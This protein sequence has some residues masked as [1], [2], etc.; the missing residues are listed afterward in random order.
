MQ[1]GAA[2]SCWRQTTTGETSSELITVKSARWQK[3]SLSSLSLQLE[4][5]LRHEQLRGPEEAGQS[6]QVRYNQSSVT[7]AI[8]PSPPSPY[9]PPPPPSP[10]R[11]QYALEGS[12]CPNFSTSLVFFLLSPSLRLNLVLEAGPTSLLHLLADAGNP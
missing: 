8:S 10:P 9:W 2:H 4:F 6:G 7:V 12:L 5:P 11:F 1:C 3:T